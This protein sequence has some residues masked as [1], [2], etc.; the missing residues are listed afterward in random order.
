MAQEDRI[1]AILQKIFSE[2][3]FPARPSGL[4]DPLRYMMSLGGK[5]L[6]PKLCLTTY[7]LYKDTFGEEITA[8]ATALEVFHN[9]TLI[10]DDIMDRSPMRRGKVTVWRKWDEDTG[11]LSGD[12]MCIDSFARLSKA[13]AQMLPQVLALFTKTA[14]EVCD[15]Q[16]LD[17]DFEAR[18]E[19]SMTEYM[20]MIGLK[21]GVLIACSAAMG[22]V[23]GGGTP[24]EIRSLYSFG[25]SIGL[26]FQ[27]AD[28]LLDAY[29]DEEVFGKP[30]GGDI[31]Q[32][33]KCWLTTRAMEKA[34]SATKAELL[35]A[36]RMPTA[37]LSTTGEAGALRR[38]K[39]E[40]VR[41]IYDRLDIPQDAKAE[42]V[43]LTDEGLAAAAASF[44][45]ERY[46]SLRNIAYR[47]V[48]RKI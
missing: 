17:A 22:A 7:A 30:I 4:Y 45:G 18:E 21:T 6:R 34:D 26:A 37:G 9:F 8:P 29:G 10:H 1:D 47:L 41:G 44:S 13:P 3:E 20:E 11:I 32:N 5:R 46:E 25:H 48:G 35:D 19:V 23:I 36:Q 24:E 42:I 16:Q 43:R 31:A 2:T 39:I 40:R 33:K 12:V 15:G 27:V 28:D 14:R 38:A